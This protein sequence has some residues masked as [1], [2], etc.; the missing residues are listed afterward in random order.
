[1]NGQEFG[2]EIERIK[3]T[4]GDKYYP[5][6]RID[7]IWLGVKDFS[8]HWFKYFIDQLISTSRQAP[9]VVDF[10]E[11]AKAE[12][13]RMW[14][15]SKSREAF[16]FDKWLTNFSREDEVM[17]SQTIIKRL[18]GEINDADGDNFQRML[19]ELAQNEKQ[20]NKPKGIIIK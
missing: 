7:L 1:M 2:K 6:D 17:F 9:M 13:E 4:F 20:Q 18:R 12:R 10:I 8:A 5:Q 14:R 16:S 11:A 19:D 15:D 3:R